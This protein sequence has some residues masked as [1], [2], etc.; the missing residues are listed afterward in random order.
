MQVLLQRNPWRCD[1]LLQPLREWLSD[2]VL[3]STAPEPTCVAPTAMEGMALKAVGVEEL[4]C[5][6]S[7][8]PASL[9]LTADQGRDVT[10]HC[11]VESD[12]RASITWAF[13][14]SL[15]TAGDIVEEEVGVGQVQSSLR[16][17]RVD[18]R[19]EGTFTCL[20][21]NRAGVT[22]A[23]YRLT[24]NT[25][26]GEEEPAILQLQLHYFVLVAAG[27]LV[28]FVLTSISISLGCILLC[29][30]HIKRTQEKA[31]KPEVEEKY[32]DILS[33]LA[34]SRGTSQTHLPSSSSFSL[35]TVTTP[36]SI[37]SSTQAVLQP[38]ANNTST[39]GRGRGALVSCFGRKMHLYT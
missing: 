29:R 8:S 22:E 38:S 15:L 6:P 17:V 1:C 23:G 36:A 27:S 26:E 24:V 7:I 11:L 21:R 19:W 33:D 2:Q 10:L 5:A 4:A 39:G 20:A 9:H 18:R 31:A 35:D 28:F 12:P 16:V 32:P 25:P 34:R 13:N 30:K 14:G 37:T 3:V